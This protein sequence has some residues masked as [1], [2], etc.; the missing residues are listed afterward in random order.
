MG[1]L[2]GIFLCAAEGQEATTKAERT[3]AGWKFQDGPSIMQS[4]VRNGRLDQGACC[5]CALCQEE[6]GNKL[7]W[8][9]GR[10]M[11]NN[12]STGSGV[13]MLENAAQGRLL[14]RTE[15]GDYFFHCR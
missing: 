1:T 2:W 7:L 14:A 12:N 6:I 9:A 4:A 11:P 8:T 13:L 10:M 15:S 3:Q 5:R